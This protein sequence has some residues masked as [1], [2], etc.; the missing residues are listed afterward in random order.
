MPNAA[1]L[2][3]HKLGATTPAPSTSAPRARRS[4]RGCRWPPPRSRADGRQN[5]L[6]IGA[7]FITRSSTGTTSAPLPLF[8]DGAGAAVI[9]PR[10]RARRDRTDR[11]RR[12]RLARRD[13]RRRPRRRPQTAWTARRCTV[14]PW[15][16]W[17][18]PRCRGRA[19][20]TDARGHRPVRLSPGQRRITRARSAKASA[21][22]PARRG[23]HREPGQFLGGDVA[24]RRSAGP[25]T[26]GRLRPGSRVLLGAFGAGFTWG[27]GVIEWGGGG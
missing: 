24:A 27:A 5:V 3:A 17:G 9:G 4:S 10:R 26:D 8:G 15:R 23:L 22:V 13:D 12:R 6:L 11:A 16:E 2:V 19:G 21:L 25:N 1:P 20:R 18:R 7:D 14:T